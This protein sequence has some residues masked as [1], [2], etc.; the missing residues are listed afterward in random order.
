[1][2]QEFENRLVK[3][4][5]CCT[6]YR[7]QIGELEERVRGHREEERRLQRTYEEMEERLRRSQEELNGQLRRTYEKMDEQ[8]RQVR[9][10]ERDEG[11]VHP[12]FNRDAD[13]EVRLS[14]SEIQEKF[15]KIEEYKEKFNHA[16][17]DLQPHPITGPYINWGQV[18][19]FGEIRID[20]FEIYK[21]LIHF[22][23]LYKLAG[24][25]SLATKYRQDAEK[26]YDDLRDVED[27]LEQSWEDYKAWNIKVRTMQGLDPDLRKSGLTTTKSFFDIPGI[28]RYTEVSKHPVGFGGR[29]TRRNK[30]R[31]SFKK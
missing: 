22:S 7:T 24:N 9:P 1:M 8:L 14:L 4:E 25:I 5:T 23:Q 21:K 15:K 26:L 3:L 31:N 29:K 11:A 16:L 12:E 18:S 30:K 10:T 2:N 13:L 19:A 28:K 6:D 27:K 20:M 17:H